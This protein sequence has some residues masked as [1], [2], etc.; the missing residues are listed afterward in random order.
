MG[1][2]GGRQQGEKG[3]RG[4]WGET[5]IYPGLNRGRERGSD[6]E[7]ETERESERKRK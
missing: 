5:E 2:G 7:R 6:R 4:D 1:R 3:G